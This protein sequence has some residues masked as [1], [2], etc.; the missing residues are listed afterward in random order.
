[1]NLL[2]NHLDKHDN[3]TLEKDIYDRYNDYNYE[4]EKLFKLHLDFMLNNLYNIK[5]TEPK[6]KRLNQT[7]FR[8]KVRS[9]FNYKCLI[10]GDSC[11]DELDTAHIIPVNENESYDLDN[12]LLLKTNIHRTFDKY[13]WSIN[14][15]TKKIETKNKNIG[16]IKNYNG[17]IVDIDINYILKE[18]LK[19][20][21]QRFI[22]KK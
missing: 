8:E 13:L 18:N 3:G 22:E 15:E 19:W 2:E 5:L 4:S 20:H 16:E 10:T 21:Y 9:R 1:M 7:E 6:R 12:G 17:T 14:P 11:M